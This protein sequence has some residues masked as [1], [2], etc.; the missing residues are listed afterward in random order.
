MTKDR[1]DEYLDYCSVI[2]SSAQKEYFHIQTYL[3][4]SSKLKILK[5]SL[6]PNKDTHN[7]Y[8]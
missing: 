2:I 5:V 4:I 7:I 8:N 6:Y 1:K 3:E